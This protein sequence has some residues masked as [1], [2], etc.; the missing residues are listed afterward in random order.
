[1][2]SNH[3]HIDPDTPRPAEIFHLSVALLILPK[4]PHQ[5]NSP[6][7]DLNEHRQTASGRKMI[8]LLITR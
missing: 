4:P 5:R 3:E 7:I 6:T 2:V 1:M 8:T